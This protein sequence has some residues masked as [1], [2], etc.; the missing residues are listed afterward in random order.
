[1]MSADIYSPYPTNPLRLSPGTHAHVSLYATQHSVVKP[2]TLE[3]FPLPCNQIGKL[4]YLK[5]KLNCSY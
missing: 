5:G 4:K 2:D 1:M 3:V